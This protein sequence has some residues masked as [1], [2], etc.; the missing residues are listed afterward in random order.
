M[1]PG[2]FGEDVLPRDNDAVHHPADVQNR[3][4]AAEEARFVLPYCDDSVVDSED[5][6]SGDSDSEDPAETVQNS[7]DAAEEAEAVVPGGHD[8]PDYHKAAQN[9]TGDDSIIS[10]VNVP[11]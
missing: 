7:N 1:L 8:T 3:N 5:D 10:V 2:F 11:L 4:D 9:N 6:L